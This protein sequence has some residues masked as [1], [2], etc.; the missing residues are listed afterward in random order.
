MTKEHK[1]KLRLAREKAKLE[2]EKTPVVNS[3]LSVKMDSMIAGLNT[4]A[5]ALGKLV[6]LQTSSKVETGHFV[7]SDN[8]TKDGLIAVVPFNPKLDDETYPNDYI[9]PKF[10]KI[11]DDILSKDFGLQIVDFPDR[12]DFQVN[13]IVPDKYSSVSKDDRMK[14]VQDIRSRIVP[15]SLGENG[16][17]EWCTLIRANL[18][19]F[20]NKEGVQS[21]FNNIM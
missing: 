16:I 20:Y 8:P 5:G 9:P 17:R 3:D 10:R 7:G 2:K 1:E 4:V 12:T 14:G 15:R 18:S 11:V 6:D 19:K 13:I 21:P